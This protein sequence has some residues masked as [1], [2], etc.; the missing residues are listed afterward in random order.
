MLILQFSNIYFYHFLSIRE[1]KTSIMTLKKFQKVAKT[2]FC[3]IVEILC[4]ALFCF[5]LCVGGEEVASGLWDSSV[6]EFGPGGAAA[7]VNLQATQ[8]PLHPRR[9]QGHAHF[10]ATGQPQVQTRLAAH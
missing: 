1:A 10:Q 4:V 7:H 3:L 9:L 5:V 8:L 6:Q 2:Q